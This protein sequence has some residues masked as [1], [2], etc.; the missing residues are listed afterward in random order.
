MVSLWFKQDWSEARCI[1]EFDVIESLDIRK[2][3]LVDTRVGWDPQ[4]LRLQK[5][6]NKTMYES[7]KQHKAVFGM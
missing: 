4:K 2:D 7:Q 5:G 3:H 6:R 1:G